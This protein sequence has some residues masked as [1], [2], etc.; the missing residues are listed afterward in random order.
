LEKARE[1]IGELARTEEDVVSYALFPQ[2][3]KSF[4]ERRARG[5]S[6]K[7]ERAAAIAAYIVANRKPK[8]PSVP[9][10]T[11]AL[12]QLSVSPWKLAARPSGG[13]VKW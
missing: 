2:V 7:E 11:A 4:L 5:I 10:T 12:L 9:V 1:E 13:W 8:A 6:F 3:A